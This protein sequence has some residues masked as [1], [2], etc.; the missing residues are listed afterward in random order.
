ML[1]HPVKRTATALDQ[2]ISELGHLHANP[3]VQQKTWVA[4]AGRWLPVLRQTKEHLEEWNEPFMHAVEA[5]R[6]I[7][8]ALASVGLRVHQLNG[9]KW[10]YSWNGKSAPHSYETPSQALEAAIRERLK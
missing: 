7:W 6:A 1:Q 2:V 4:S 3:R 9:A 5:Q 8:E 10:S